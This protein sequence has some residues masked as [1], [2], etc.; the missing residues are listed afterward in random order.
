[1]VENTVNH[2]GNVGKNQSTQINSQTGPWTRRVGGR[3]KLGN[4]PTL[5]YF[6]RTKRN[7]PNVSSLQRSCITLT[8]LFLFQR[9]ENTVNHK[10]NV[11]KNQSTQINSQTG[12]WTHHPTPQQGRPQPAVHQ[13]A[14]TS[15]LEHQQR[16]LRKVPKRL[17]SV[18]TS[19]KIA[20][21]TAL[22]Q[23]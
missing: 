9:I 11:G 22:M 2:K 23:K 14:N 17:C 7:N 13:S 18:R 1:M 10:G 12:P 19:S 6:P 3:E 21:T 4:K 5:I 16:Y 8:T 15:G 20:E